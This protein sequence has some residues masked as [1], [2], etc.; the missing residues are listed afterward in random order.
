MQ[1]MTPLPDAAAQVGTVRVELACAPLGSWALAHCDFPLLRHCLVHNAGPAPVQDL[2][3]HFAPVDAPLFAPRQCRIA[4]MGEYS[5]LRLSPLPLRCDAAFLAGLDAPRQVRVCVNAMQAGREVARHTATLPLLPHNAWAGLG[6]CPESLAA[7]VRPGD[8]AVA[9]LCAPLADSSA[10]PANPVQAL[11]ALRASLSAQG[12]TATPLSPDAV[13]AGQAMVSPAEALAAKRASLLDMA[14]LGA[15]VL[16]RLGHRPVI[17]L[18]RAQCLLG[19][20]REGE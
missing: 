15:A 2:L 11:Q 9:S 7:F 16:E 1:A 10:S 12:F 3:L 5:D 14:V 4:H 20:W 19:V 17:L 6:L 8:P 18:A 13:Q